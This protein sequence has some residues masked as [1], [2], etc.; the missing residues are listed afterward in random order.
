[1]AS[2]TKSGKNSYLITIYNGSDI[3]GSLNR[4]RKT[5]H[6]PE[7]LGKRALKKWLD[8]KAF[9]IENE[10]KHNYMPNPNITISELGK[11]Y[12]GKD[13]KQLEKSTKENEKRIFQI[14]IEPSIGALKLIQLTSFHVQE[15][16]NMLSNCHIISQKTK[17]ETDK[18]LSPNTVRRYY[19]ILKSILKFALKRQI[20]NLNTYNNICSSDLLEFPK[21][22]KP[23]IEIFTKSE[24]DQIL[25]AIQFEP[26]HWQLYLCLILWTGARRS[27]ISALEYKDII[28]DSDYAIVKISKSLS[29]VKNNVFIKKTKTNSTRNIYIAASIKCLL[30]QQKIQQ[31]IQKIKYKDEYI[32]SDYIFTQK[33]GKI[34]YPSS[35]S[36][37][38]RSFLIK[39]NITVRSIHCLRHTLGSYLFDSK[40]IS[41]K[42]VQFR[43]GHSQS[44]TTSDF[45]LHAVSSRD[46]TAANIAEKLFNFNFNKSE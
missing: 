19:R 38:F 7:G 16:I 36:S 21:A 11:L 24:I 23:N 42:D 27:E 28:F 34:I 2:Y 10:I 33:N 29:A 46:K 30:E 37:W 40:E 44:K 8:E 32:D 45:Y 18:L 13:G 5:V 20:I 26:V 35:P 15:F 17:E 9:E 39:N 6:P 31:Q 1:M 41:L 12:F 43:L 4:I 25:N 3:N 14:Y 22:V